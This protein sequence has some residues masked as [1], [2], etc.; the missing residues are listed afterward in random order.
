LRL[1]RKN[2]VSKDIRRM[3]KKEHTF[4]KN[5]ERLRS[6]NHA[7]MLETIIVLDTDSSSDDHNSG[8]GATYKGSCGK[9]VL[10]RIKKIIAEQRRNG[11][12]LV[13]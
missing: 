8:S 10:N 7:A 1:T 5:G 11:S 12:I 4:C 9:G 2:E 6:G 3:E 13:K